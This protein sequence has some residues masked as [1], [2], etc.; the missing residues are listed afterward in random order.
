EVVTETA[1]LGHLILA[2]S[3]FPT[4]RDMADYGATIGFDDA[5]AVMD[6][7]RGDPDK[8][9]LLLAGN[10]RGATIAVKEM[11]GDR[12]VTRHVG[13]FCPRL[14][15][16][17]NLPDL[18]LASRTIIVPLVRSG[19]EKRTKASVGDPKQWPCDRRRLVDDLWA[20]GLAHLPGM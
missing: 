8:R 10:R 19:D 5:E 16:A 9:T 17:I 4:L 2:G 1:Y 15:S 6:V 3:S 13:T 11:Q 20:V 14:F 12:W 7:R 18:V